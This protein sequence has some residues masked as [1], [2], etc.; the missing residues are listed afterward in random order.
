MCEGLREDGQPTSDWV[1]GD[2]LICDKR[3]DT[4]PVSWA[5]VVLAEGIG[6]LREVGARYVAVCEGDVPLRAHLLYVS[7]PSLEEGILLLA[8]LK[9][10]DSGLVIAEQVE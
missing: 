10:G 6:S 5:Q 2:A 7:G 9:D 4:V 8:S 1:E 3:R